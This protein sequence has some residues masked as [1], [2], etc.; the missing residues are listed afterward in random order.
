MPLEIQ[1][2]R[3][4][5]LGLV[6]FGFLLLYDIASIRSIKNRFIFAVTGYGIQVYAIIAAVIAGSELTVSPWLLWLGFPVAI[7]GAGWLLYCL[8]LFPPLRRTYLE[9]NG[10][11]LTTEGPY[12]L[13]RHPGVYGY[14]T[15]I[16]GLALFSRSLLLLQS[17]LIWSLANVG[18]VFIQD[19]IIFPI[20]FNGYRDYWK[21]T[22]MLIPNKKSIKHFWNTR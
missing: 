21:S 15:L 9:V 12:A 6:G 13:S 16:I 2:I 1:S 4:I 18:Y 17:G 11:A 7:A 5:L 10:P 19:R 3:I 20:L 22:P 14:T 8:F